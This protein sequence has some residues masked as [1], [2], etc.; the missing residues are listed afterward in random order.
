MRNSGS[1][2]VKASSNEMGRLI[3]VWDQR[4]HTWFVRDKA[5]KRASYVTSDRIKLRIEKE[6]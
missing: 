3:L 1:V 5:A 2:L 4:C 6:A